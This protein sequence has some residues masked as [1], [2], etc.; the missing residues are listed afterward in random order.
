[1]AK[2]EKSKNEQLHD[3][4]MSSAPKH[5]LAEEFGNEYAHALTSKDIKAEESKVQEN[6]ESFDFKE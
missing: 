5:V 3:K 6:L 2:E 4:K 1:M